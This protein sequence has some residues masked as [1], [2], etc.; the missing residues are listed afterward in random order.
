MFYEF[1]SGKNDGADYAISL[2][3]GSANNRIIIY[4]SS[5]NQ[6]I[7]QIRTGATSVA[8]INT[9]TLTEDITYKVALGYANNDVVFYVNGSLIGS[10]TSAS[11][12]STDRISTDNSVG[13]ATFG[14]PL[15]QLL[16]F[17]TRLSN[18]EL[19]TLTTI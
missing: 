18:D 7:A 15:N 13:S 16:L 9:S 4:R 3:D 6:L 10:D 5:A 14:R 11:I 1:N 12:P 2:S 17:K 19:A 8:Q